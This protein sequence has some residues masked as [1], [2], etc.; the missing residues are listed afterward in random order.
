MVT[1]ITTHADGSETHPPHR[2]RPERAFRT[3]AFGLLTL[4]LVGCATVGPAATVRSVP[5]TH[6]CPQA[7]LTLRNELKSGSSAAEVAM[8]LREMQ[9][10]HFADAEFW[11]RQAAAQGDPTSE[12]IVGL[13]YALG[14][15]TEESA[16]KSI[17]WF[18]KAALQGYTEAEYAVGLDYQDGR[19]V[20]RSFVKA[21]HWYHRAAVHGLAAA[22][23]AL[24]YDFGRG[25]GVTQNFATANYWFRKAALQGFAAAES[26]LGMD[27][28]TGKGSAI[29]VAAG[30][31][32]ARKAA[33]QGVAPAEYLLGINYNWGRGVPRNTTQ[34]H[35]WFRKAAM[36]GF[37]PAEAAIG[38]DYELGRGT[39]RNYRKGYAWLRKAAAQ[40]VTIAEDY[41]GAA[42]YRGQGVPKSAAKAHWWW[43]KAKANGPLL[44]L[45]EQCRMS[46]MHSDYIKIYRR[47]IQASAKKLPAGTSPLG[48]KSD[49]PPAC[50]FYP[51]VSQILGHQ[52]TAI[53]HLCI[54]VNGR[55]AHRPTIVRST[56][57]ARLDAAALRYVR[58]T[59]GY[60]TPA[61]QHGRPVELCVKWP[62][63]FRLS[64]LIEESPQTMRHH[65]LKSLNP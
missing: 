8:G 12:Y 31:R 2:C 53:V 34:G 33:E 7:P 11:F 21:I 18:R 30:N 61:Q 39:A 40:N 56:G 42:Y 62:V 35:Y 54:G 65:R 52:G 51:E 60:W 32:W 41:L 44:G 15:G 16:G 59:S 64:K 13:D 3:L 46:A 10:M 4:N 5:C 50:G 22:Q 19:G 9:I 29:R 63:R 24:G 23:Y 37:P 45:R 43:R 14:R 17:Y 25:L 48:I 26:A 55:L 38:I 20:P 27:Y 57:F 49:F 1:D 47:T 28:L 6:G 36:S 58:A